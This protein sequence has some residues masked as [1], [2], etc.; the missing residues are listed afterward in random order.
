MKD[1]MIDLGNYHLWA[2]KRLL[3]AIGNLP[4][5]YPTKEVASSFPSLWL[6]VKHLYRAECIWLQRLQ[7]NENPAFAFENFEGPFSE[8]ATGM[9][10]QD[11]LLIQ[12]IQEQKEAFF[13]HTMAYYNSQKQYFKQPVYQCLQH[14]FYHGAY[15]RGQLVTMLHELGVTKIPAT[16]Y[17]VFKR[18]KK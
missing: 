3:D 10:R 2:D 6:T 14:L 9:I 1:L 16:D 5:D 18:S 11:E 8:L 13:E 7:M 4:P 12:W 17:I 15:H